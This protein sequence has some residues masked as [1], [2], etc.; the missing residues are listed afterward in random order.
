M[1]IEP[2]NAYTDE[3]LDELAGGLLW[4]GGYQQHLEGLLDF[5]KAV[6]DAH[7]LSYLP[8]LPGEPASMIL[9]TLH[10][11]TIETLNRLSFIAEVL[12]ATVN[13]MLGDED[14]QQP[15]TDQVD[16]L[17]DEEFNNLIHAT[18]GDE[19]KKNGLS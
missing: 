19:A 17:T 1:T 7:L 18:F 6:E 10:M 2:T 15:E 5:T 8:L 3:R 11:A 16:D 4:A 13:T 9:A 12:N 14:E